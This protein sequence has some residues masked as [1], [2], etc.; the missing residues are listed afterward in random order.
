M[1]TALTRQAALSAT[2]LT[3]SASTYPVSVKPAFGVILRS[4]LCCGAE[5]DLDATG[6]GLHKLLPAIRLELHAIEAAIVAAGSLHFLSSN[7]HSFA[8]G[9]AQILN[10]IA[11]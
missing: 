2:L 3:A 11:G 6:N 5:A 4:A 7:F 9:R 1:D 8:A 10:K